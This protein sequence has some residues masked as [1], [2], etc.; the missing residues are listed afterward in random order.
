MHKHKPVAVG[1]PEGARLI[2]AAVARPDYQDAYAMELRPGMPRDPAAWTGILGDSFPIAA[3]QDG[4]A[5]MKVDAA[6]LDAWASIV[7][8]EKH[9]TLCSSVKATALRSKLY[10]GVVRWF[11]PFMARTMMTRTHRRLARA[12]ESGA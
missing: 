5:L 6:G 10:W 7:I 1:F 3:Q 9:V 11:H 8:D 4:E 12:A 2:R